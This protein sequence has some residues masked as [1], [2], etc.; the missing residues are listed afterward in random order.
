[1]GSFIIMI[2]LFYEP[3]TKFYDINISQIFRY[4][5]LTEIKVIKEKQGAF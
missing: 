5:S 4:R 2:V 3:E 1:M